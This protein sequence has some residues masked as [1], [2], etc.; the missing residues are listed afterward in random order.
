MSAT[1]WY[2]VPSR[3]EMVQAV[4]EASDEANR[5]GAALLSRYYEDHPELAVGGA[6]QA[7][8]D[9]NVIRVAV[10][11]DVEAQVRPVLHHYEQQ[12]VGQRRIVSRLRLLSP[13]ILMQDA[14]N[15]LSGTGL[16]RHQHFLQQVGQFHE[17]WRNHFVPLIFRKG[18]IQRY[19]SLPT[20][21]FS[22]EPEASVVSRAAA[23]IALLLLL[24]AVLGTLGLRRV[25][26]FPV[27]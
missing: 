26:R 15:D 18:Q 3:V 24:A 10:N 2:P 20:F 4:R 27:V 25:Q 13:A 8:N 23:S 19:A 6:E 17:E 12:L 21:T 9:F 16:A 22:E 14:L 7:M 5:Q 11:A 1:T